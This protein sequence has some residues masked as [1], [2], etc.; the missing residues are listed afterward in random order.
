MDV[1]R[2][3]FSAVI[4]YLVWRMYSTVIDT[5]APTANIVCNTEN[6]AY[7]L[8]LSWCALNSYYAYSIFTS[9][10]RNYISDFDSSTMKFFCWISIQIIVIPFLVFSTNHSKKGLNNEHAR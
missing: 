10:W 4:G 2:I 9:G 5:I 1:K 6:I 7:W 8:P 3:G